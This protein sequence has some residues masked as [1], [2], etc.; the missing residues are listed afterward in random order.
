M[1][2][3]Q[4]RY[5]AIILGHFHTVR[6]RRQ[7]IQQS[8]VRHRD[9]VRETGRPAG[10][11]QVA[12][13]VGVRLGQFAFQGNQVAETFPINALHIASAR[14]V[15]CHVGKFRREEQYLGIAAFQLH[16]QL[17]DIAFLAA[18]GS[19]KRKRHWPCASIH[20][21][22]EQRSEIWAGFGN[23]GDTVILANAMADKAIGHF[24]GVFTHF[25]VGIRPR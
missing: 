11:L 18:K 14:G 1:I 23:Q 19:R 22:K 16:R 4:P 6:V 8:L 9:A 17:V 13:F 25:A 21:A 24:E 3:W 20:A 12:N 7:I 15:I 10:I 2:P 5:A